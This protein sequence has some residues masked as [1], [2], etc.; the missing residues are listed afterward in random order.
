MKQAERD[1]GGRQDGV[2]TMEQDELRR[3]RRES[4]ALREVS[5]I[6]SEPSGKIRAF[7]RSDVATGVI[8]RICAAQTWLA[9]HRRVFWP[10]GRGP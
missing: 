4:R 8:P 7:D 6:A 1:D 3:L 5:T 2:T 9:R 10:L